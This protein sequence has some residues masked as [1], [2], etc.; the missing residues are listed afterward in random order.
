VTRALALQFTPGTSLGHLGSY[1]TGS[2]IACHAV[3]M[4]EPHAPVVLDDYDMLIALGGAYD[5]NESDR[6]P[7]LAEARQIIRQAVERD[8]PFLGIC[9]GGQLLAHG[10][11]AAVTRM[12][13]PEIGLVEITVAS[14]H[15]DD[16]LLRSLG[17]HLKVVEFHHDTFVVPQSGALLA[18]SSLCPTQIVRCASRAYALQFHPEVSSEGFARSV[19]RS[20]ANYV[21]PEKAPNGPAIAREV[22]NNYAAIRAHGDALFA[23]F[24]RLALPRTPWSQ[25]VPVPIHERTIV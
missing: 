6:Y 11:G 3:L 7:F 21:A 16:P 17:P 1:L 2:G 14:S 10:L 18:S 23:N 19:E 20:Y 25:D 9:L 15:R 5:P 24:V 8:V 13:E 22:E 4:S 12:P